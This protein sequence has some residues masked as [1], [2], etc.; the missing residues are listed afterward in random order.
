MT[1]W[2]IVL[3]VV[4]LG[5]SALAVPT[6]LL[7]V[8][9]DA[10]SVVVRGPSGE[11]IIPLDAEGLYHVQGEYGEV[12]FEAHAGHVRCIHSDCDDKVCVHAGDVGPGRPVVCAPNGVTAVLSEEDGAGRRTE[13]DAVSR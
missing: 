9:S 5:L 1:R 12:I 7:S 11:T 8:P 2:D 6:V 3:V 4:L 13:L 10:P